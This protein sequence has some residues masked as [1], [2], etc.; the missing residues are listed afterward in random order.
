[1]PGFALKNLRQVGARELPAKPV[2]RPCP[3][4][5]AGDVRPRLEG[6]LD[7]HGFGVVDRREEGADRSDGEVVPLFH[8]APQVPAELFPHADHELSDP[9]AR[10]AVG[11][12]AC[13]MP[14]LPPR[15]VSCPGSCVGLRAVA[16]GRCTGGASTWSPPPGAWSA[17]MRNAS[18]RVEVINVAQ[19]PCDWHGNSARAGANPGDSSPRLAPAALR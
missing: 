2:S 13:A 16:R 1:F 8:R 19:A 9:K 15:R 7:R 18:T 17:S 6:V 5:R 12:N 14:T 4:R 10:D 3:H 11:M